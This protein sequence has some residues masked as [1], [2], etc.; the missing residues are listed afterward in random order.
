[1]AHAAVAFAEAVAV[2][3]AAAAGLAART[4]KQNYFQRSCYQALTAFDNELDELPAAEV[5]VAGH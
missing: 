1:V 2:T 5:E 3:A 4:T